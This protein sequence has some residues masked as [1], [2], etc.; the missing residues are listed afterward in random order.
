METIFT[1]I[2]PPF[3]FISVF[4]R[5]LPLEGLKPIITANAFRP[6]NSHLCMAD[7]L[8]VRLR[9]M[10]RT[11]S[12]CPNRLSIFFPFFSAHFRYNSQLND[13]VLIDFFRIGKEHKCCSQV[14]FKPWTY[15]VGH[16]RFNWTMGALQPGIVLITT[17]RAVTSDTRGPGSNS[18]FSNFFWT[19]GNC[20]SRR[21]NEKRGREW[22]I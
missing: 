8:L 11:C 7:L 1:P 4:S 3:S 21:K 12:A 22:L 15:D 13:Y 20:M 2:L 16:R 14:G 6:K 18:I 9:N 19:I 17:P 5:Y 10:L